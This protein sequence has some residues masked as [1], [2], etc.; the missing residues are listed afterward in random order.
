MRKLLIAVLLWG[1]VNAFA[2][3]DTPANRAAEAD[4]YLN[5]C[6]PE[7]TIKDMAE[8]MAMNMPPEKRKE[9]KDLMTK[10]LDM[11]AITKA[12]KNAMVKHFTADELKALA[13][14]YG[15]DVGKSAL[16]KFGLYM[17][18]ASPA[19]QAEVLKAQGEA[20]KAQ[21]ETNRQKQDNEK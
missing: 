19:I 8:K 6:P 3:D 12:I 9:F 5:A 18:D 13:D 10:Y 4:R 14:F 2:S 16:K 21:A 20:I 7:D 1:A 17:A 15:S 11:D